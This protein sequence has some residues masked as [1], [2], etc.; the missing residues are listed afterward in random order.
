MAFAEHWVFK[1][2]AP[3][4]LL[5]DN[6]PQFVAHF[7]QRVC[8]ILHV[9]NNFTTTYHP[10]TN[11]QVEIFNRS[12]TA[13]LRCFVED[14][15]KD[16]SRYTSVL[17]YSYNMA[18]HRTTGTTPFDL[19]LSRPPPEFTIDHTARRRRSTTPFEKNDYACRLGIAI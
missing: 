5:S 13:M 17:A 14:N 6:G 7:F 8:N 12:L 2:G 3:K 11:G 4:T 19:V 16:W 1:Y 18:I 15:P 9:T 10:Q